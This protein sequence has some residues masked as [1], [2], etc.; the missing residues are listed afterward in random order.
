MLLTNR[1]AKYTSNSTTDAAPIAESYELPLVTTSINKT[2]SIAPAFRDSSLEQ[3]LLGQVSDSEGESITVSDETVV[4]EESFSGCGSESKLKLSRIHTAAA[5]A[6]AVVCDGTP[7]TRA[8][9]RMQQWLQFAH[10][11]LVQKHGVRCLLACLA[12]VFPILFLFIADAHNLCDSPAK[13][14]CEPRNFLMNLDIQILTG[15]FTIKALI[16]F[17][18]RAAALWHLLSNHTPTRLRHNPYFPARGNALG[19]DFFGQLTEEPFFHIPHRPRLWLA[20]L[21]V[22]DCIFQF[23]NQCTRVYFYTYARA[24]T[25]PGNFWV[26]L[27]W[28]CSF[29]C[30]V[31]GG[32]LTDRWIQRLQ[33]NKTALESSSSGNNQQQQQATPNA[34]VELYRQHGP[35]P[36]RVA[37]ALYQHMREGNLH[38]EEDRV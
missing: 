30:G 21:N 11:P 24:T 1:K 26:D 4:D 36:C 17:P 27:F 18:W 34:V 13:N 29:V 38:S 25:A 16:C 7:L 35:N 23:L 10:S 9:E 28:P 37:N 8:E 5:A 12:V 3:P 15:L 20:L 31:V 14:N 33:N 19:H 22:G 6:A 32:N 2:A